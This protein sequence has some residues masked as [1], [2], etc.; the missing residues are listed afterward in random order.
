MRIR[1]VIYPAL[2][3][4]KIMNYRTLGKTGLRVSAIALGTA[5]FGEGWGYGADVKES[6]SI[7]N[8]YSEAGGNFIDTADVYQFGQSEEILGSLLTGRRD[9]FVLATKFS[10]G[11]SAQSGRLVTGN[12]RKAMVTSLEASLKRLKTDRVDLSGCIIQMASRLPKRLSEDLK[13][14]RV[15]A[16]SFTRD[17]QT[18]PHGGWHMRRH[19]RS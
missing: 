11:S 6:T 1:S 15:Q 4:R 17:C 18:S 8:A 2:S 19:W 13:T 5:N 3:L 10:H 14:W 16:R 7:F 9:D 12:S